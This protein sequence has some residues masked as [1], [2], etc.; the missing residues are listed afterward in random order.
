MENY[1]CLPRNQN[2]HS[3]SSRSCQ[4]SPSIQSH[5]LK[6]HETNIREKGGRLGLVERGLNTTDVDTQLTDHDHDACRSRSPIFPRLN[7][8]P[9][10]AIK[11]RKNRWTNGS[12][13]SVIMRIRKILYFSYDL[14]QNM[15]AR[16][17]RYHCGTAVDLVE[18][19]GKGSNKGTQHILFG[20]CETWYDLMGGTSLNDLCLACQIHL[21]WPLGHSHYDNMD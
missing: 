14:I 10:F 11:S 19:Y 3:T 6:P 1:C 8:F 20:G 7:I 5:A 9:D 17:S 2:L 12:G 21:L 4:K 13:T 18:Q 15:N 16:L